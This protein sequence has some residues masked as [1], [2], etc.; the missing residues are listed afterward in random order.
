MVGETTSL[1]GGLLESGARVEQAGSIVPSLTPPPQRAAPQG[2]KDGCPTLRIPKALLPYNIT[3]L[4]RQKNV[5][6]MKEQIKVP[7]K[8]LS[9]NEIDNL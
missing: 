9:N 7:E 4:P 8:E 5:A 2:S 6:Q 1:T 3:G